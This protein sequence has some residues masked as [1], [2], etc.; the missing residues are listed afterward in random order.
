[1]PYVKV[2]LTQNLFAE[3]PNPC[4]TE[5]SIYN[6]CDV[7]WLYERFKDDDVFNHLYHNRK[8]QDAA[9]R[10]IE[11]SSIE[12]PKD[13]DGEFLAALVEQFISPEF[14]EKGLYATMRTIELIQD[15]ARKNN[16]KVLYVFSYGTPDLEIHLK[17]GERF[18]QTLIDFMNKKNLPYVDMLEEHADDYKRFSAG[19]EAYFDRYFI[20]HKYNPQGN[21]F[22]A[23]AIREKLLEMLE[24]KPLPYR[25]E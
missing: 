25:E 17:G 4:P 10:M 24:P 2:D 19:I 12:N 16:K 5:D 13:Q 18:D 21:D 3:Y 11:K 22:Q 9:R 7:D 14:S 8:V 1:M 23:F 15:Y 6:L 20:K